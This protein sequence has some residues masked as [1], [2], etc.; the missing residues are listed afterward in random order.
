MRRRRASMRR[1]SLMRNRKKIVAKETK[2]DAA[3]R[4][5]TI[6]RGW[7]ARR[8]IR[9]RRVEL[10]LGP[11]VRELWWVKHNTSTTSARKSGALYMFSFAAPY[12]Y[13]TH[14][15]IWTH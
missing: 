4:I 14:T 10:S 7:F 9:A 13:C 2:I 15:Y 12:V 3:I 5:Q 6:A 1:E 8:Q 11:R